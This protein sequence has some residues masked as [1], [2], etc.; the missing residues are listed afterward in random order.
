ML[1]EPKVS[2][3]C[4]TRF[5]FTHPRSMSALRVICAGCCSKRSICR[6][7]LPLPSNAS[8]LLC[9]SSCSAR[10]ASPFAK[11]SSNLGRLDG[12]KSQ[13]RLITDIDIQRQEYRPSAVLVS[14]EYL[15]SAPSQSFLHLP[16]SLL[17]L[18]LP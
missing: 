15:S 17:L 2:I 16:V 7:S 10:F 9:R 5:T 4:R 18:L 1:R 14:A 12:K 6:R 11:Q 8:S 13:V 3:L